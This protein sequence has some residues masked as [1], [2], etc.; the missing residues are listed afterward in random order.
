[1]QQRPRIVVPPVVGG[2][3]P[4]PVRPVSAPD[5]EPREGIPARL[6]TEQWQRVGRALAALPPRLEDP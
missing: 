4:L 3:P 6:S 1:M 2:G 5:R